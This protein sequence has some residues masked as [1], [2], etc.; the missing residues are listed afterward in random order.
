MSFFSAGFLLFLTVVF[1]LYYYVPVNRRYLVLLISSYVFYAFWDYRYV[2]VLL[3]VTMISYTAARFMDRPYRKA[4]LILGIA[5]CVGT[6]VFFKFNYVLIGAVKLFEAGNDPDVM[7]AAR[8]AAPVGLSFYVLE[9]I[10]YM[11]DVYQQKTEVQKDPL[12]YALFLSFFPIVLSGPIERSAGLLPQIYEDKIFNYEDVRHGLCMM[13]WGY[14]MKLLIADRI[15]VIV[16][17]AYKDYASMAGFTLAFAVVL[18]GVQL[19]ADFAGY[20]FIAVGMGQIFGYRIRTN[21]RQPYLSGSI[22]EFWSRWHISLS[23]WLKDYIYI[24]LGGN[25]RGT[26]RKCINLMITFLISG[27][28]HGEG[29]QFMFWGALHGVYQIIGTL[30][31]RGKKPD[32]S[33]TPGNIR[34]G[35]FKVIRVIITFILVDLAWLFFRAG[36]MAE[37]FG[38]L[39]RIMFN[40]DILNSIKDSAFLCGYDPGRFVWLLIWMMIMFAVD[41][42]REKGISVYRFITG[43]RTVVRW[44]IYLVAVL[45]LLLGI[46]RDFGMEASE[47]IYAR[48]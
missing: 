39:G 9:A 35:I 48:F 24:P 3:A 33:E 45:L 30:I 11:A 7:N 23:D 34:T 26:V 1:V 31:H 27:I 25:R 40:P 20:S 29:L 10:G 13:L 17:A 18:Y 2:A 8:I 28:W 12:R 22:L 46:I 37:G 38:I 32:K 14:M 6:L 21:F 5:A 41:I 47:F 44:S 4:L 42:L 19:Y 36:S 43:Q 15:S 16:N